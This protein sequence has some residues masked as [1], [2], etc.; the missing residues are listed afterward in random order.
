[1]EQVHVWG[2]DD[3]SGTSTNNSLQKQQINQR[4]LERW[5]LARELVEEANEENAD[6]L[7]NEI[8]KKMNELHGK[9]D[10]FHEEKH[11]V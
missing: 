9:S 10:M 6:A 7:Y 5:D 1:M 2:R 8:K 3:N 4:I 11:M